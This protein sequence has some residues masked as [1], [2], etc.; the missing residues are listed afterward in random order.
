MFAIRAPIRAVSRGS[1]YAGGS[2]SFFGSDSAASSITGASSLTPPSLK[3]GWVVTG[4]G[5]FVL[6]SLLRVIGASIAGLS[7]WWWRRGR[8]LVLR[9][10]ADA[11]VR[12]GGGDVL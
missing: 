12:R 5:G 7:L 10:A 8:R 2:F 4:G 3:G 6:G 9:L 11:L 1:V